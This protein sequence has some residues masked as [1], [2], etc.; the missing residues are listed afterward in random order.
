[1]TTTYTLP[2]ELHAKLLNL[3]SEYRQYQ[4]VLAEKETWV[5]KHEGLASKL[6][7][8]YRIWQE[9]FGENP[10]PP[11]LKEYLWPDTRFDN[12]IGECR[13]AA[14]KKRNEVITLQT[15]I[16]KYRSAIKKVEDDIAK[17]P[18]KQYT[19]EQLIAAMPDFITDVSITD[20]KIKISTKTIQAVV[21]R[22]HPRFQVFENKINI[23]PMQIFIHSTAGLVKFYPKNSGEGYNSGFNGDSPHPHIMG[24][25]KACLGDFADPLV[26]AW[27]TGDLVMYL[28]IIRLFLSQ[29]NADGDRAGESWPKMFFSPE[30]LEDEENTFIIDYRNNTA[31]VCVEEVETTLK[32]EIQGIVWSCASPKN[33]PTDHDLVS[34]PSGKLFIRRLD[35]SLYPASDYFTAPVKELV[36]RHTGMVKPRPWKTEWIKFWK[37]TYSTVWKVQYEKAC[38]AATPVY[39]VEPVVIAVPKPKRVRRKKTETGLAEPITAVITAPTTILEGA[40]RPMTVDQAPLQ[41]PRPTPPVDAVMAEL[42]RIMAEAPIGAEIDG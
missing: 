5:T 34:A 17:S 36:P 20:G 28:E 1:M 16:D 14:D 3:Q 12:E 30:E 4:A 25:N 39:D 7:A 32:V 37:D 11:E 13:R 35:G 31:K 29:V 41:R 2:N 9:F 6:S 42:D 27:K 38:A 24:D 40:E 8:H 15:Q 21:N 10:P 23:P 33:I 19:K 26:Q 18:V 22:I